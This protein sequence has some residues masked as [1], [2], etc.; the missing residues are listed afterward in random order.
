MA[1]LGF[2]LGTTGST[3]MLPCEVELGNQETEAET[4]FYQAFDE[5][6]WESQSAGSVVSRSPNPIYESLRL[7]CKLVAITGT[8]RIGVGREGETITIAVGVKGL[9]LARGILGAQSL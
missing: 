2:E 5:Q 4:V 7:S 6:G 3:F 1:E 8:Q 9:K